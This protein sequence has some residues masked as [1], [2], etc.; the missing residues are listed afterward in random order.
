MFLVEQ[1]YNPGIGPTLCDD[2]FALRA[3]LIISG[4]A[5]GDVVVIRTDD[6]IAVS[7]DGQTRTMPHALL[8]DALNEIS[9]G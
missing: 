5:P 8:V 6:V 1:L 4:R 7:L 9:D 2:R 3:A